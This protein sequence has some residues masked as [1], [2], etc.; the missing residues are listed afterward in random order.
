MNTTTV[1]KAFYPIT[2][3]DLGRFVIEPVQGEDGRPA[4]AVTFLSKVIGDS[5]NWRMYKELWVKVFS[6][7]ERVIYHSEDTTNE[8]SANDKVSKDI[9]VEEKFFA[10]EPNV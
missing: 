4:F 8:D 2:Q 5:E 1:V 9:H 10:G 7:P 3:E 6:K